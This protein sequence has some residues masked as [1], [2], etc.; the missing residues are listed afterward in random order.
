MKRDFIGWVCV[1]INPNR[2]LSE[3]EELVVIR[4]ALAPMNALGLLYLVYD[5][6][7]TRFEIVPK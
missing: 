5:R 6:T 3:A 1:N 4:T 7:S 2:P